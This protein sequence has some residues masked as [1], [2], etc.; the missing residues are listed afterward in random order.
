MDGL[1][2]FSHSKPFKTNEPS[3]FLTSDMNNIERINSCQ[4]S[5]MSEFS[6]EAENSKPG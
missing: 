2:E 3:R 6:N 5:S 1:M 4:L